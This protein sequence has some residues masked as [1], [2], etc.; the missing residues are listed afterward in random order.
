MLI[1]PTKQTT[2]TSLEKKFNNN[3][4]NSDNNNVINFSKPKLKQNASVLSAI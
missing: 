2:K 4:S 3:K 1:K